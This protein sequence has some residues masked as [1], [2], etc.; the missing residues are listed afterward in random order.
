MAFVHR[1][2]QEFLAALEL[3][4]KDD[5]DI[6]AILGK[7]AHNPQWEQSIQFFFNHIRNSEKFKSYFE[8]VKGNSRQLGFAIALTNKNCPLKLAKDNFKE[9]Q[10]IFTE[11]VRP[12]NKENLLK[13]ILRGISNAKLDTEYNNF[14]G[15]YIPN[16][17]LYFD[18][19]IECLKAMENYETNE[20][21]LGF[22]FDHLLN[23]SRKERMISSELL[24]KACVQSPIRKRLLEIAKSSYDLNTRAFALN[25]LINENTEEE[26]L[27]SLI[28]EYEDCPHEIIQVYKISAK[29]YLKKH[30][31]KDF[32]K[33]K[34]VGKI[35]QSFE[36]KDELF[37]IY[38][39]GWGKSFK[40]RDLCLELLDSKSYGNAID[41]L[42]A[43]ML[44]FHNF[45]KDAKVVEKLAFEI[46]KTDGY[47]FSGFYTGEDLHGRIAYYFKE[48]K[49]ITD[50]VFSWLSLQEHFGRNE[51]SLSLIS[52]DSRIKEHIIKFIKAADYIDYWMVYPLVKNWNDEVDVQKLLMEIYSS[53][54]VDP[55]LVNLA[56]EVLERKKG[57]EFCE[58]ILYGNDSLRYQALKPLLQLGK[59]YFRDNLLENFINQELDRYPKGGIFNS[60]WNLVYEL[61]LNFSNHEKIKKLID[62]N[63]DESH[64][65]LDALIETKII[66]KTQ[67]NTILKKCR[68]LS[69]YL[70]ILIINEISSLDKFDKI[71][72]NFIV[73]GEN[74]CKSVMAYNYFLKKDPE[75]SK[76]KILE[77]LDSHGFYYEINSSLGFLGCLLTKQI[78]FYKEHSANKKH[79]KPLGLVE[80][81]GSRFSE[82]LVKYY[83]AH[84]EYLDELLNTDFK[85]LCFRNKYE[86]ERFCYTLSKYHSDSFPSKTY[87]YEFIKNQHSE[88][89]TSSLY[90]FL[91][92]E[93]PN[94]EFTYKVLKD[95]VSSEKISSYLSF[96]LGTT[97][98]KSYSGNMD[99]KDLLFENLKKNQT[100]CLSALAIGWNNEKVITEHIEK[101]RDDRSEVNNRDLYY[102]LKLIGAKKQDLSSFFEAIEKNKEI[103]FEHQPHFINPLIYRV[104]EEPEIQNLLKDLLLDSKSNFMI[105]LFYSILTEV[106]FR[107]E[108]IDEWVQSH[109]TQEK[110]NYII[111]YNIVEN[112]YQSLKELI[113]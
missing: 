110:L 6:E 4:K 36:Y 112:S 22:L 11:E 57:I 88:L 78:P 2:F 106:N 28:D 70:R 24:K 82:Y 107:S 76:G 69:S 33:L 5:Q 80:G 96:H 71:V 52:K 47:I 64:R 41:N 83:D 100:L 113:A 42:T 51:A 26:T 18:H 32:E 21:V 93:F 67:L 94:T 17:F 1:Q 72:D 53:E 7:F 73:E 86:E 38:T 87:I 44:L 55:K 92:S 60:Y 95:V 3:S 30:N 91:F 20:T 49:I 35:M 40:L 8:I 25:S 43:W 13:I 85:G 12:S 89:K 97:I 34:T 45:N 39:N 29:I 23:G 79:L 77:L 46:N 90:N 16:A 68:P 31:H 109:L 50:S 62:T 75:S 19:R 61:I 48:N 15:R 66:D 102:L 99:V 56:P 65:F 103:L 54:K 111:G 108:E 37:W 14:V 58:K 59:K 104:K 98:G 84:F 63:I 10:N 27:V 105:V 81:S 74:D 9:I 101:I